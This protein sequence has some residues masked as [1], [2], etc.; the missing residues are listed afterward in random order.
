MSHLT[1]GGGGKG[2]R[3]KKKKKKAGEAPLNWHFRANLAAAYFELQSN[4]W[5][6]EGGG[7]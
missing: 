4:K 3:E 7:L 1:T 5:T 6:V 2:E